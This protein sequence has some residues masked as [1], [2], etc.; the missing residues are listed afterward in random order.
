MNRS[1]RLLWAGRTTLTLKE[2]RGAREREGE[3]GE[4]DRKEG[5]RLYGC[6]RDRKRERVREK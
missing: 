1:E 2:G 3:R 6:E 4:K 5:E